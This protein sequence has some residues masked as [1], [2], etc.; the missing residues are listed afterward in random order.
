MHRSSLL[1]GI[2]LAIAVAAFAIGK[3]QS[4]S[5][6]PEESNSE[7]KGQREVHAGGMASSSSASRPTGTNSGRTEES[8][9]P[10]AG[11][12]LSAEGMAEA[13]ALVIAETDPLKRQRLFTQLLAHLTPENAEAAVRALQEAPR[14]RWNWGQEYSLLTYAWGRLDGEA[15]V[16][17]AKEREGRSREWT[18]SSVLAGWASEQ[19][20]SAMAWV[21]GLT[22]EKER[23][24]FTRG[25]VHGLAQR[26]VQNATAY[27]LKLSEGGNERAAE[28]MGAIA[29]QQLSQ[30]VDSAVLW[31]DSLPD[32]PIKGNALHT[33]ANEFVRQDPEEAAEWISQYAEHDFAMRALSEISEEWAEDEP[34]AAIQWVTTLPEGSGRSHAMGEAVSEWAQQDPTEAGDFINTLPQGNERDFALSSYARRVGYE[35]PAIALEWAQTISSPEIRNRTVVRNVHDWMRRQPQEANAWI[36]NA[37][38]SET[39]LEEINKPQD[40]PRYHRNR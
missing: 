30:G 21:E 35:E 16:A 18:M 36:Q 19:P 20:E 1:H 40:S 32:G 12:I 5:P 4:P 25:L 2:W 17:F 23:N 24:D 27:V 13:M 3:I 22:N 31:S 10:F 6:D 8:D 33:I 26:D 37:N 14:S 38:L 39:L 11:R 7:R 34:A 28:Y 29:R 9:S 15:A